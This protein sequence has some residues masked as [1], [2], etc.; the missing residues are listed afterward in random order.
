MFV[1]VVASV[2]QGCLNEVKV[3]VD[4]DKAK[5]YIDEIKTEL[6]IQDGMEGESENAAELFPWAYI[7]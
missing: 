2:Y 7:N 5:Q 6:G 3:F 1:H 4:E